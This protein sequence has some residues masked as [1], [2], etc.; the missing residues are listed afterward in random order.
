MPTERIS[1]QTAAAPVQKEKQKDTA[2][3]WTWKKFAGGAVVL[4]MVGVGAMVLLPSKR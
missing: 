4:A 2:T 3:F 1:D